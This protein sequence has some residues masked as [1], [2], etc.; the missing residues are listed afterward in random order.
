MFEQSLMRIIES[1]AQAHA[2]AGLFYL[3]IDAFKTVNDTFGHAAGDAMLG[4]IG[5]RL[6]DWQASESV[7]ARIGGDEFVVLISPLRSEQDATRLCVELQKA[8]DAPLW[9]NGLMLHPGISVGYA[10]YPDMADE[11]EAL[12][13]LAD[14]AMYRAKDQRYLQNQITRW[15]PGRA[16]SG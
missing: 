12:I 11:A 16:Q 10:I 4:E 13:K 6:R 14:Q 8:L 1:C 5:L 15:G 9:V 7:A 3:D 2:R